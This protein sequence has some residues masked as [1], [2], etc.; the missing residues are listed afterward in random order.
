MSNLVTIS[1]NLSVEIEN[2]LKDIAT[3]AIIDSESL[4]LARNE[5]AKV[6]KIFESFETERKKLNKAVND[7]FKESLKVVTDLLAN[8]DQRIKEFADRQKVERLAEIKAHFEMVTTLKWELAP[9]EEWLK[10]YPS[11]KT[12]IDLWISKIEHEKG[13]IA[14]MGAKAAA[15]FEETYDLSRAI[16]FAPATPVAEVTPP[17]APIGDTPYRNAPPTT[18]STITITVADDIKD[19]IIAYLESRGVLV[20]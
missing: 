13:A 3:I 17:Q 16:A 6:N 1:Y 8:F 20:E 19:E 15:V 18:F 2:R 12:P 7:E 11:F 10:A 9:Q 4:T 14:P 5:R